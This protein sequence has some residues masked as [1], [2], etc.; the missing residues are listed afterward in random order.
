MR[1]RS[2]KD[3]VEEWTR[4]P[5]KAIPYRVWERLSDRWCA[6]RDAR[7]PLRETDGDAMSTPRMVMLGQWGRGLTEKAWMHHQASTAESRIHLSE[8]RARHDTGVERLATAESQLEG[9]AAPTPEQLTARVSGEERTSDDV[10]MGRRMRE[11]SERRKGLQAEVS[12]CRTELADLGAEIARTEESLRTC[13]EAVCTRAQVI[14]AHIRRRRAAYLTYLVRK[15]R[16]G[17]KLGLLVRPNWDERPQWSTWEIAPGL[18]AGAP[19]GG[20]R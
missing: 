10:R 5:G 14:E 1:K 3:A 20:R 17:R 11:H 9:L 6:G 8:L 19:E 18:R 15:H 13:F 4:N 16:E 7:V 12:R 2:R